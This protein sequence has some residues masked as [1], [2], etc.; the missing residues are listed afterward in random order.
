MAR[1][2][3][4]TGKIGAGK[5]FVGDMLRKK[6][7][8]VV[9]VGRV[10]MAAYLSDHAMYK[11]IVQRLGPKCLTDDGKL[12]LDYLT[13]YLLT[14]NPDNPDNFAWDVINWV[15]KRLRDAF[16]C[17]AELMFIEAS[18]TRQVGKLIE[19]LHINEAIIVTEDETIRRKRL[20]ETHN[21]SEGTIDAFDNIQNI[22]NIHV[23]LMTEYNPPVS[24]PTNITAVELANTEDLAELNNRLMDIIEKDIK[25]TP[26]EKFAMYEKYL[27]KSPEYCQSNAMCYTFYNMGGCN[28][29]PFPC[30]KRDPDFKEA[31]KQF[32]AERVAKKDVD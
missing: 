22:N 17:S 8:N 12:N 9:N 27:R 23:A 14:N 3:L 19:W 31:N 26:V 32:K 29:C 1:F 7:Y 28:E 25:P 30:D 18:P 21:M 11:K 24:E 15:G 16:D 20:I 10:A 5:T 13:D 2:V 6:H 4:I